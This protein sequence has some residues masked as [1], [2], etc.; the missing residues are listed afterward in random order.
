ELGPKVSEAEY[1]DWLDNDHVPQRLT[2]P[3]ITSWTRAKAA[4]G[5]KPTWAAFYDFD[6]YQATQEPPYSLLPEKRSEH[7]KDLIPRFEAF[8]R[9]IYEAYT[10]HPDLAPSALYDPA[11]PAPVVVFVMSGMEPDAEDEF[12]RW[13]NEEHAPM[14]AKCPGWIRTRRFVLK[15]AGYTGT[16][17]AGHPPPPKY[18]GVHEWASLDHDQTKD[19]K[20]A[21]STPWREKVMEL[22]TRRERRKF[23]HWKSYQRAE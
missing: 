1:H 10:G 16:D 18:L 5:L 4:D 6:S 3:S 17:A 22:L 2:I 19:H 7:E 12:N 11:K 15:E 8:D 14:L 23:V 20:A 9:R 21:N 13:Y